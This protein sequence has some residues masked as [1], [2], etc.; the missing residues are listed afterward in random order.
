MKAYTSTEEYIRGHP[1]AIQKKLR[2]IRRA[3]REEVPPETIEKISYRIPTFYLRQN[4]VHFAAFKDHI[5]FF[6]TSSGVEKY[7]KE[8]SK[9]KSSR[10]TIQIPLSEDLP[11]PLIKKIVRFRVKEIL[12][13]YKPKVCSR[14]HK[15]RGN[16]PCPLCWP[17]YRKRARK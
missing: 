12:T 14:G 9:Y 15:Y 2:S 16:G 10:G 1:L 8:L 17:N 13:K 11:M 7:K 6:P 3:I 5:S 4:L